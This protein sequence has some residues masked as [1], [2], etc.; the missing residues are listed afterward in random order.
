M[1]P[2]RLKYLSLLAFGIA[3]NSVAV[4]CD[5]FPIWQSNDIYVNGQQAS[6]SGN[7]YRAKWWTQNQNPVNNANTYDVWELLGLCDGNQQNLPPIAN[8]NGPYTANTNQI[9]N[10]SSTGS[11]DSDGNLTNYSWSFGDGTISNNA[12][13]THAYNSTGTYTLTLTVTDNGGLSNTAS[14]VATIGGSTSSGNCS[15]I[16]NY[17]VGTNYASGDHVA[18]YVNSVNTNVEF[19]CTIAGWCSSSAGWAYEPGNGAHWGSAW[20]EIGTC[21]GNEGNQP[22]I[23]EANGPYSGL[24]GSIINFSSTGSRDSDGQITSYSWSFGDGNSSTQTNPSHSYVNNGTYTVNLTVIDD[25]GATAVN[26]TIAT[27]STTGNPGAALPHRALVG[28][29]H[30]FINQAGYL[31]IA[32]VSADWDIVNLSFAENNQFGAAGEVAFAPAE[33]SETSFIAGVQLLQSRGQKVLISLGGAN[34][35]I[36][37]NS[38]AERDNF[39]RTMGDIIAHYNL[40]GMDIDL[41]GGSLNMNSGD[42]IANPQT[43]AIVNLIEAT[44]QIKARFGSGFVLTMAPETAYVQGG[45]ANFGGIWGAYLPLINALRNDLTLLHVQHYNTGS[46]MA[47]NNVVYSSG[48]QDFHVALSDMMITGFA[49]GQNSNNFFAGLRSDQIA[50]GLPATT[51]AA[52][53]GQTQASVVHAALDCLIKKINCASYIPAQ[54]RS[55]FRGLMTWSINWDNFSNGSFSTPHRTYL[56]TNP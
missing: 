46:I 29:W 35:H 55:D 27:I 15:G 36:T 4:N 38:V 10:F 9:I 34:A 33:E 1:R 13:P 12:N 54:A 52:S 11:A 2:Q 51:G 44:R 37:L 40:D 7:G 50:I 8:L 25:E 42:T 17:V 3:T 47:A 21:S 18:N 48:T 14:G 20:T 30:N 22:P 19:S 5:S 45:Y 28:Y 31:P 16:P 41:E 43:P 56:N 26:S 49:A 39:V 23:A 24:T 32:N 53:S 6:A